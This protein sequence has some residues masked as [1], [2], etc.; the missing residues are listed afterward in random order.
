M[1]AHLKQNEYGYFY[2]FDG[3][4]RQSLRTKSKREAE[5]RLRQYCRGKF[6][7]TPVPTVGRYYAQWITHQVPP[8]AR[9]SAEKNYKITFKAHVLPKFGHVSLTDLGHREIVEFRADL[10]KGRS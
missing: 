5:A 6:G 1:P 3:F 2:L 8:L 7:L 10:L 9:K 4:H